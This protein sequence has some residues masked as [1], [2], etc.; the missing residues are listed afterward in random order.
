MQPIRDT[1]FGYE[2]ARHLLLRAGFGGTPEQIRA[3][4]TMGPEGAVDLLLEVERVPYAEDGASAF[5]TGLI[6]ALTPEEREQYRRAARQ[7][8]EETLAKFRRLQQQ[9][10]RSDRQQ[11]ERMQRWWLTRMIETPRPLE[12]KLT[13]FWHGHF[14]ASHRKVENSEQMLAQNRLFRSN[15]VG[16]YSRMLFGIVRDPA[17]LAYLDNQN[18]SKRRPNENLARELMELFS[19]GEGQYGETDIQEGARAL[20]GYSF[21]GAEFVFRPEAHDDGAKTILGRTGPLDGEGFVQAI[22]E[23]PACPRFIALKLY[24]FFVDQDTPDDPR[25]SSS[26]TQQAIKAIASDIRSSG[27][28]IRPALR[29]L[30]LSQHFYDPANSANQIKSPVELVVGAVRTLGTP[31]RD[32]GVLNDALDRMGQ[33][34][35]FPPSVAGWEGGRTWINTSTLFVRQNILVYLLTG[36]TP[37]GVDALAHTQRYDPTPLLGELARAAPGAERDPERVAEY[38]VRLTLGAPGLPRAATLAQFAR[39]R[40]ALTPDIITAMLAFAT[41]APEYQLT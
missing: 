10:E 34:L 1:E 39:E 26:S 12:E 22:L 11:I 6:V 25:D 17:M 20:T 13:L 14:A 33:D 24:R 3:L 5:E 19:L 7:G 15:A 32:L 8:D 28:S 31:V 27:Y 37:V 16:D 30:F 41:A 18:S 4:T 38:L 35:F 40:G 36:R 23:Q 2:Q 21:D 9:M 29:R